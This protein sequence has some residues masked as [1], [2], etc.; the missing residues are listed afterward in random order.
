VKRPDTTALVELFAE[1]VAK[2]TDAIWKGDHRTGNKHAKRYIATFRKLRAMGDPGRD[3]LAT[4]LTHERPD[5][6]VMAAAYL[7][8]H[9]TTEAMAVLREAEKGTGMIAFEAS[10]AIKRWE[11]GTWA[12]DPH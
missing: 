4:L 1:D 10:Q 12:L 8:R 6:R 5:V 7:L 9:R 2:Q 3:A 11:E